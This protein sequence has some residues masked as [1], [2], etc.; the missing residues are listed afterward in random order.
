MK[1]T[2]RDANRYFTRPEPDR[3]SVLIYGVDAM[4]V[5]IKRQELIAALIGPSGD[6]EMRLTRIPAAELRKDP[7]LL[8]DAIKAQG[9]FPGPRVAFVEDAADAHTAIIKEALSDWQD[10]DAQVVI[11]AKQLTTRSSLRKFVEG[12]KNAYAVGLYDD[13]PSREDIQNDLNKAGV[14]DVGRDAMGALEA[15]SRT[16]DPGD[17]RQTM[18]KLALYK[19]GDDSPVQVEDIEAIAPTSTEAALDDVLNIVAEGRASEVGPIIAK[20]TSQG[21]QP[22]RL[23]IGATRHFR[24]LHAVSSAPGGPNDGIGKLRPPVFGPRRDK[25]LRQAQGWGMRKVEIALTMLTDTDLTLRSTSRAPAM[26]VMER[27]LV[28]LAMLARR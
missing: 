17:F 22:V 1:L 27:T 13:P 24:Q 5:A 26:A 6:D 7:A 28:R 23:C 14:R 2:A 16:I 8:G 9:F 12:H 18:E 20:L 4:R 21:V 3:T 19:R 15:L 10:G 25:M 11:T